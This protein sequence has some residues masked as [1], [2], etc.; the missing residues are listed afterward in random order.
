LA[1]AL[2]LSYG[3]ASQRA[4]P[5]GAQLPANLGAAGALVLLA[6]RWGRS[7]DDLGL[8]PAHAPRGAAVGLA[9]VPVIAAALGAA[10][11]VPALRGLFHDDRVF[12][13]TSA[14]AMRKV[15][16]RVPLET[17]LA[18][19]VVFR[20]SLLA[21]ADAAGTRRSALAWSS[22]VFGLWHVLPALH[23]H[24]S[25]SGTAKAAAPVGGAAAVVAGTV[26]A[27]TAAGVGFAWLRRRSRS[28]LAPVLAHT[29]VNALAFLATRHVVRR[30]GPP[31]G[32]GV[33]ISE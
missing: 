24:R 12:D 25:D 32:V 8:D 21:L 3:A 10:S 7:W 9:T 17:A 18:E 19:E 22:V 20:G 16:V 5:Q 6:R 28:V 26:I 2:V 4:I 29:A 13:A 31:T 33:A 15:L 14:E 27:T 11:A 1:S 23:S 30:L